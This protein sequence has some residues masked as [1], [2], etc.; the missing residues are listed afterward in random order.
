MES[1]I[2]EVRSECGVSSDVQNLENL[3]ILKLW[4]IY[5]GLL[6]IAISIERFEVER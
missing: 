5:A 2:E 1:R 6:L 3:K 4:I